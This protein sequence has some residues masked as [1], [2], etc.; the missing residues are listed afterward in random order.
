LQKAPTGQA[1]RGAWHSECSALDYP[2]SYVLDGGTFSKVDYFAAPQG[3]AARLPA[4]S[5]T[6][7]AI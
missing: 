5:I 4:R 2:Q 7:S 1:S 6:A 3:F